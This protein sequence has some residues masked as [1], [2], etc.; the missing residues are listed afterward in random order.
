MA[1][2]TPQEIEEMLQEF[3]D[4][5][6]KRQYV[7]ARYVP[8]FGRRGEDSIDWDN[9]DAYEPLTIVYYHGDTYTSKTYVPA[10]IDIDNTD[11]WCITGRYNAQVEAYRQEVLSFSQRIDDAY[12]AISRV[13]SE[14]AED[15]VPFPIPNNP[16]YGNEGQVLSTLG[17]GET[18]WQDPVVPSDAQA[19]TV[20]DAWLD[21]HPEATTTVQDGAVTT[22][23]IADGAVTTPKIAD[24]TITNDKLAPNGIRATIAEIS[25]QLQNLLIIPQITVAGVTVTINDDGTATL[26]GTCNANTQIECV[27]L[28]T[29]TYTASYTVISGT[30]SSAGGAAIYAD[31]S[32]W[33]NVVHPLE[34]VTFATDT[35]IYLAISNGVVLTNYTIGCIAQ[36]GTS[37]TTDFYQPATANDVIARRTL[38]YVTNMAAQNAGALIT[39]PSQFTVVN[40]QWRS[41]GNKATYANF[42]T[43][44]FIPCSEGDELYYKLMAWNRTISGNLITLCSIAFFDGT[45]KFIEGWYNPTPNQTQYIFEGHNTVPNGAKYL[46]ALSNTQYVPSPYLF[47]AGKN[48]QMLTPAKVAF[49]GDSL[50]QGLTGGASPSYTFAEK[51]YPTIMSEYLMNRGFIIDAKNYG[52]R[53]LSP[54][55]YWETAIPSDGSHHSP[56]T[57]EPGDTIE[58]DDS[59]D[60]VIIMLGT[61]GHLE[62]GGA[63]QQ[64]QYEAYCN[65]IEYVMEETGYHAQIILVAPFYANDLEHQ[66]KIIDTLPTIQELGRRYQLPVINALYES[67]LGPY[68]KDVFYNTTDYVHLNQA[69]YH[70]FGTFMG[71]KFTS[72]YSTFNMSELS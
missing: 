67:G 40:E 4:T 54:L 32:R 45:K 19:E 22:A 21:A 49:V 39:N 43:T 53:G 18:L 50:T 72:L 42:N 9:S 70:K 2:F 14:V 31:S 1:N 26:N 25:Q 8:I 37:I 17:N 68:N 30:I 64:A 61:N 57:G 38:E 62:E 36:S 48:A 15:Y 6:G 46:V 35:T 71:S 20:I 11:Y 58:F 44:P 41:N 24:G 23:K 60:A 5:V 16:K 13:E 33:T 63:N 12:L 56:N 28:P 65:I 52:R 59:F 47:K 55:S 27:T 7:G 69:G 10:G 29:G 34:T 51:P 3:F 66:Q